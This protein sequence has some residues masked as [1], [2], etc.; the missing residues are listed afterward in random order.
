VVIGALPSLARPHPKKAAAHPESSLKRAHEPEY[1]PPVFASFE[2][3][4]T[5]LGRVQKHFSDDL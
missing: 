3:L 5:L 4:A 2:V 1:V